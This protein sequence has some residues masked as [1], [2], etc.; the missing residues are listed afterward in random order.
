MYDKKKQI[1]QFKHTWNSVVGTIV[2]SIEVSWLSDQA[3]SEREW[4]QGSND[5]V[6][7]LTCVTMDVSEKSFNPTFPPSDLQV[8]VFL[9]SD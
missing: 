4:K 7:N 2:R 1:H 9:R 8:L 3:V 6:T 5:S